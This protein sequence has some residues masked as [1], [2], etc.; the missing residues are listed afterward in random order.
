[1]NNKK[2]YQ[3]DEQQAIM[4]YVLES[5][6]LLVQDK[7]YRKS[8]VIEV[9]YR[10]SLFMYVD[11]KRESTGDFA[12]EEI[13]KYLQNCRGEITGGFMQSKSWRRMGWS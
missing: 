5:V 1:M 2:E 12:V 3:S 6:N 13:V 9:F 11:H 4:H 8:D 10:T 7:G